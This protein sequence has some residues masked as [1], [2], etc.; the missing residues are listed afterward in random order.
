MVNIKKV[1]EWVKIYVGRFLLFYVYILINYVVD[2][3][4]VVIG[5]LY[6]YL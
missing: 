1:N 3:Y 4:N 5:Y 6:E 2:N